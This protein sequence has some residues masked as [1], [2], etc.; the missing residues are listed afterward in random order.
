MK[1]KFSE[2]LLHHLK[3]VGVYGKDDA[4]IDNLIDW[5][6]DDDNDGIAGVGNMVR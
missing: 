6:I 3:Q 4:H 1:D 2:R 5:S